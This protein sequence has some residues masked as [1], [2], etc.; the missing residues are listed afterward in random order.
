MLYQSGYCWHYQSPHIDGLMQE[1]RN[2][3]ALA[4][5]L[6]LS[7]INPLIYALAMELHLSFTNPWI[8]DNYF[9]LTYII[10]SVSESCQLGGPQKLC[11]GAV[12]QAV[13]GSCCGIRLL[14]KVWDGVS[15]I[16]PDASAVCH[17]GRCIGHCERRKKNQNIYMLGDCTWRSGAPALEGTM[18]LCC[19]ALV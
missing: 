14:K 17:G 9:L 1:R 16:R 15:Q 11:W 18:W 4:M 6:R 8:Y 13:C 2:S 10:H 19:L 12:T 5:E 3:S 7:C